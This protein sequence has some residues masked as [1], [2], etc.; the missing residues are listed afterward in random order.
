[1]GN[2]VSIHYDND[3]TLALKVHSTEITSGEIKVEKR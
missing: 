2:I 1:M 3:K